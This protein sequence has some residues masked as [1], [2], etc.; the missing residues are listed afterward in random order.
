MGDNRK[1]LKRLAVRDINDLIEKGILQ[2][3]QLRKKYKL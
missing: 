1:M 2:K 3:K